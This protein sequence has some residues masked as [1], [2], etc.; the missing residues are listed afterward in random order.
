MGGQDRRS[1]PPYARAAENFL[2]LEE[3][4]SDFLEKNERCV[5]RPAD[6]ENRHQCFFRL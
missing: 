3:A 6:I 2:A 4:R 1:P 5:H